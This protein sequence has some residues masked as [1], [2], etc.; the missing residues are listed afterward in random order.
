MAKGLQ[1]YA[2]ILLLATSVSAIKP[3]E[4]LITVDGLIN[5]TY[6]CMVSG[7]N[8]YIAYDAPVGNTTCQFY[9]QRWVDNT[10]TT[11]TT[12]QNNGGGGHSGG[13]SDNGPPDYYS[14]WYPGMAHPLITPTTI[15][16]PNKQPGQ[17]P[18]IV[19]QP[20]LVSI[21]PAPQTQIQYVD[22]PV[23]VTKTQTVEVPV[24][25]EAPLNFWLIVLAA[26]SILGF[27][28]IGGL[29]LWLHTKHADLQD[30]YDRIIQAIDEQARRK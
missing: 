16:N 7:N 5:A 9:Y 3:G 15:P 25:T 19:A 29:Y 12:L 8:I 17:I 18:Q 10:T 13:G 21:M 28:I 22:K 11:T 14:H 20:L 27:F 30:K 2:I 24:T 26:V 4:V 1:Y 6:P 23:E